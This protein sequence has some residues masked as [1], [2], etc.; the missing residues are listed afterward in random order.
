MRIRDYLLLCLLALLASCSLW[1]KKSS[2]Q[3]DLV[4]G[5][6]E[7]GIASTE[8]PPQYIVKFTVKNI[9]TGPSGPTNVYINAI[10]LTPP[11]GVNEIRIQNGVNIPALLPGQATAPIQTKFILSQIHA[12]EVSVMRILVDP[13]NLVIESDESNN[14]WQWPWP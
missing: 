4:V 5:S 10:N 12:R 14:K 6:V 2:K 7:R 1:P 8:S 13:K 11:A 3:P 9:G